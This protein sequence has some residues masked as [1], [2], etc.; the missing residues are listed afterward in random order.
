MKV[1]IKLDEGAVLP[2]YSKEGDAGMDLTAIS[3]DRRDQFIQ[4]KTGVHVEI[5]QGYFG[6]VRPRSSVS[7]TD[8]IFNTSGIIDSG[9]RG[10]L[11]VRFK[12]KHVE[13]RVA[14]IYNVGDRVCQLIILPYPAI[15]WEQVEELEES[16]RGEGGHGST[17]I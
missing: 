6:L 15:E 8:L 13:G 5:P 14:D 3:M 7:N 12:V 9:Y 10:D 11:M 1:K 16:V 4:Y 17:G 2:V